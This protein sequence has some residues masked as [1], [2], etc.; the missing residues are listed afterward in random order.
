[1]VPLSQQRRPRLGMQ[2][3]GVWYLLLSTWD[4][5]SDSHSE[6]FSRALLG[7]AVAGGCGIWGGSVQPSKTAFPFEEEYLQLISSVAET[8]NQIK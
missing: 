6:E 8:T 1:M 7:S 5:L 4:T 3:R 2:Q